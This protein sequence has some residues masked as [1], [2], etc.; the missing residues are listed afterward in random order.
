[1]LHYFELFSKFF[2]ATIRTFPHFLNNFLHYFI[3]EEQQP[4]RR[5]SKRSS[6]RMEEDLNRSSFRHSGDSGGRPPPDKASRTSGADP[7]PAPKGS[8][9]SHK[10]KSSSQSRSGHVPSGT[11]PVVASQGPPQEGH[12][13]AVVSVPENGQPGDGSNVGKRGAIPTGSEHGASY[14]GQLTTRKNS[15]LVDD[16]EAASR[17]EYL[18]QK[19]QGHASRTPAYSNCP[20]SPS[21]RK[22]SLRSSFD[23]REGESQS[24][25]ALQRMEGIMARLEQH[26]VAST[27]APSKP[28]S[29]LSTAGELSHSFSYY[30][31]C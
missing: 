9:H 10:R 3:M 8:E 2:I 4:V 13:A 24:S 19:V 26:L 23:G 30:P 14:G 6:R 25:L 17:V 15:S 22:S 28:A 1:M 7:C 29:S 20:P 21:E 16:E 18:Y 27:S 31:N 5:S 11:I 12:A